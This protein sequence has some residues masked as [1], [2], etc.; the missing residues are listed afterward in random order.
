MTTENDAPGSARFFTVRQVA[1]RHRASEK[2]VRREIARGNLIAHRF[3]GSLR[4]SMADLVAYE[5]LRREA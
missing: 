3:G 2:T 5:R 4:I 1:E